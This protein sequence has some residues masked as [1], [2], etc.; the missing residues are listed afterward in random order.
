MHKLSSNSPYETEKIGRAL[1]EL[2]S[3]DDVVCLSGDLGAGKT[4][5]VK[6][7]AKGLGITEQI[8]SPT[9]TIVN[10]YQ[11]TFTLY[12]FDVY[13]VNDIDELCEIG[14]E[15][16]IYSQGICVIEWAELISPL[17]PDNKLWVEIK[18]DDSKGQDFREINLTPYGRRYESLVKQIK[19]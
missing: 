3:K 4:A 11:G 13:R 7:L 14:F 16:Y 6:G 2:L 8:T 1:G 17:L 12:H 10:E 5:F 15:E 9:F 19:I 18:R